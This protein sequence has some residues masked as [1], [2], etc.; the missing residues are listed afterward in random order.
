[1][2]THSAHNAQKSPLNYR[3]VGIHTVGT[4]AFT[5]HGQSTMSYTRT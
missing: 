3:N 1:M 2:A 5:Y 4:M